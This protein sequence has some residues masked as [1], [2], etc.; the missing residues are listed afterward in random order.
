MIEFCRMLNVKQSFRDIIWQVNTYKMHWYRGK[1][2]PETTDTQ[3]KM[4]IRNDNG[5]DKNMPKKRSTHTENKMLTVLVR[6]K[7]N[8]KKHTQRNRWQR[9]RQREKDA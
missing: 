5:I 6:R 1:Y 8:S 4:C 2:A 3:R 9:P 7:K